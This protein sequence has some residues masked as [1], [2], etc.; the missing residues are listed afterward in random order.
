MVGVQRSRALA[1][2][3][4]APPALGSELRGLRALLLVPTTHLTRHRN[5]VL[6]THRQHPDW[7]PLPLVP[8]P[9]RRRH[10]RVCRG[11]LD[12]RPGL[13]LLGQRLDPAR[14]A[15]GVNVGACQIGFKTEWYLVQHSL[16]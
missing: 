13:H 5:S 15:Q 16:Q 3:L 2:F 8:L 10:A 6:Y 9:V 14:V 12:L 4:L 1:C 11:A 7:R